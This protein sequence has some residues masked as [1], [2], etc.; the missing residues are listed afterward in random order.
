MSHPLFSPQ[1][2][3]WRVNREWLIALAGP[4]AI[5]L[6]LA[7]PAVAAGIAQHSNYRGDPFG[8]LY[9]TMKTMTEISFGTETEMR[10]ALKH[11]HKCH[12]RVHSTADACPASAFVY[13]ARDPHLQLWVW[14]TLLDSVLRVYDRFVTPLTF[15]DKCAYYDDCVRLAQFLGISRNVI[16]STYTG[17]NLYMGAMLY[18]DA[19]HV[20]QDSRNVVNALFAP[21]LRGDLTRLFS[22]VGIGLLPPRLRQEYGFAWDETRAKRVERLASIS[23][24][25]RPWIPTALAIHPKAWLQ[26]RQLK[27]A[28]LSARS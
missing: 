23:R 14:A 11:F 9:R 18:G 5:L 19:L 15:A 16:P 7:H 27:R 10:A 12:A 3:Y 26:E 28:V 24:R 17:F 6:E 13:D 8:R 21:S 25:V 20:T 22:S 1:S 4:R 2:M